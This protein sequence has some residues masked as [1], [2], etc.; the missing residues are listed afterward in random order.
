ML[1]SF[2]DIKASIGKKLMNDRNAPVVIRVEMYDT[3]VV[4]RWD[5]RPGRVGKEL[6]RCQDWT[7]LCEWLTVRQY[8][9]SY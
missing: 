3:W 4:R 2:E 6:L 8:Q 5:D 9:R 1:W 7:C